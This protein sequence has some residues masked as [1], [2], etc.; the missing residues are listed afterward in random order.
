MFSIIQYVG[1]GKVDLGVSLP[2]NQ[3]SALPP[4]HLTK[5]KNIKNSKEKIGK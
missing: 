4:S 2:K 5:K 1:P 3:P